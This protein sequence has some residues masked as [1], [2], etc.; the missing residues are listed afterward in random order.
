[1]IPILQELGFEVQFAV[2][3]GI[4]T[5]SA[6]GKSNTF[7]LFGGRDEASASLIQGMTLAGVLFDEVALMPKSIVEQALAR[8]SVEGSKFWFNCNPG[9]PSHWFYNEWIKNCKSKNALY[10]HFR[11]QENPSLSREMLKRYEQ[12]YEGT[13]Y[14][15]YVLGRWVAGE[16]LVYPMF[17]ERSMAEPEGACEKYIISCDYGTVNPSSFGLWGLCRGVWYRID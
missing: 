7:Y 3:K 8:C 12:L 14:E 11:M 2:S 5:V 4:M 17:D 16:G 9:H 10:L 1:M 13:F 15:R 6:E